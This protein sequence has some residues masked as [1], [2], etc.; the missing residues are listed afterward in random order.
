DEIEKLAWELET[1]MMEIRRDPRAALAAGLARIRE[2]MCAEYEADMAKRENGLAKADAEFAAERAKVKAE[3][4]AERARVKAEHAAL[5]AAEEA[6]VKM[7]LAALTAD[8]RAARA[9]LA[10]PVGAVLLA[11]L[12]ATRDRLRNAAAAAEPRP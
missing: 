9:E 4:A 6:K 7:E 10:R 11:K 12:D 8:L 5:M 2:T 1:K 3:F